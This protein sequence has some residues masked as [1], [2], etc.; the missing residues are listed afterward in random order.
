M[1][2]SPQMRARRTPDRRCCWASVPKHHRVTA[3]RDAKPAIAP[4]ALHNRADHCWFRGLPIPTGPAPYTVRGGKSMPRR[5]AAVD[6]GSP[7]DQVAVGRP[8]AHAAGPQG[9]EELCA[10]STSKQRGRASGRCCH[11]AR[12]GE[13]APASRR[14]FVGKLPTSH[15]KEP[16]QMITEQSRRTA[17][18]RPGSQIDEIPLALTIGGI[19]HVD[20]H[21]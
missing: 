3:T 1:L 4:I 12:D 8:H 16:P 5:Q 15:V 10:S 9:A 21:H 14:R 19:S 7:G 11:P 13:S 2:S 17:I 20:A 6:C 18:V